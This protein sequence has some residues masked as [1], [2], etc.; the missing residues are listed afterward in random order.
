MKPL[1]HGGKLWQFSILGD[2]IVRREF[3]AI[4]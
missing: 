4:G 1:K 2:K 3:C